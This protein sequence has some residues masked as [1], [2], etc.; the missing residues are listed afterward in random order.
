MYTSK[1]IL[2][3]TRRGT[4]SQCRTSRR[5]GVTWSNFLLLHS[6]LAAALRTDCRQSRRY[7]GAPTSRLLYRSTCDVTKAATAALAASKDRD[8]MEPFRRRSWRKQR[9]TVR[10]KW[11]FIDRSD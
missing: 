10:A 1:Q 5:S 2:N 6:S 4:G 3:S 7:L 8:L 11:T 9:L